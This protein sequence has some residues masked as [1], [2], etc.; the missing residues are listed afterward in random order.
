MHLRDAQH[1]PYLGLRQ[2]VA[3]D[4]GD[5]TA[6]DDERAVDEGT[7]VRF[8]VQGLVGEHHRGLVVNV[9]DA[10]TAGLRDPRRLA[11]P[12]HLETEVQVVLGGQRVP[13]PDVLAILERLVPMPRRQIRWTPI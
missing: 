9:A 11:S 10:C 2:P 13:H 4:L 12:P 1:C 7:L 6:S 3:R 8:G 5:L